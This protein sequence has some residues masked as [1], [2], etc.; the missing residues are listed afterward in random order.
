MAA[1]LCFNMRGTIPLIGVLLIL[2]A[3][4]HVVH[5]LILWNLLMIGVFQISAQ[6][7]FAGVKNFVPPR[8]L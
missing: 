2:L 7:K 8:I 4:I 1:P 5:I 6:I 3:W